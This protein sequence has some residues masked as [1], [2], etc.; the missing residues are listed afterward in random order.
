[1]EER[2]MMEELVVINPQLGSFF[3][4]ICFEMIESKEKEVD[5]NRNLMPSKKLEDKIEQLAK[6]LAISVD[7]SDCTD[8]K[9]IALK[10]MNVIDKNVDI[11]SKIRR[12]ETVLGTLKESAGAKTEPEELNDVVDTLTIL[13][14]SKSLKEILEKVCEFEYREFK[15]GG[16]VVCVVCGEHFK[17]SNEL[18]Q[19]F[20][21]VKMCRVFKSKEEF[22]LSPERSHKAQ[23]SSLRA[24]GNLP[25]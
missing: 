12:L 10:R 2:R 25:Y 24:E 5:E 20:M 23:E 4:R 7:L 11:V 9:E 3:I 16:S 21:E 22:D 8:E 14:V 19:D 15:E 13:T 6:K 17:Y 1:M 18:E